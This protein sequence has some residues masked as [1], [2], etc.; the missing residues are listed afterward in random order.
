MVLTDLFM[1]FGLG[2]APKGCRGLVEVVL[3]QNKYSFKFSHFASKFGVHLMR[4][5]GYVCV[6]TH[7]GKS[8]E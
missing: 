6:S 8:L 2:S 5:V 4:T 3:L 1:L 7:R